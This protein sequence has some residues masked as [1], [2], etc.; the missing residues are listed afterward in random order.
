MATRTAKSP[1][2]KAQKPAAK[3]ASPK[4]VDDYLARASNDQRT[5]L[6]KIRRTIKAAA[7]NATE[8]LSY[9]IAGYKYKGKPL[10]YLGYAK[11]HCAVYGVPTGG[12]E[13]EAYDVSKGT[14][15][16]P[17]DEPL[18]VRLVTKIVKARVAEIE[19]A[20]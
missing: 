13:L 15:R 2:A 18:P 8:S 19:Q 10:I 4:S 6:E 14:I 1:A 11:G 9:G 20:S 12:A 5:A 3:P 7:P 17:A 16:F